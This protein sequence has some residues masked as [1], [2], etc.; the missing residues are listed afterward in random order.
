M[1]FLFRKM[2][3]RFKGKF[4]LSSCISYGTC[5]KHTTILSKLIKDLGDNSKKIAIIVVECV[6]RV[7]SK[8]TKRLIHSIRNS[9]MNAKCHHFYSLQKK[10]IWMEM[11]LFFIYL[12]YLFDIDAFRRRKINCAHFCTNE[13]ILSND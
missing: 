7:D 11:F 10:T 6:R 3:F 4:R 2:C 1:I 9:C 8:F 5:C 13:F 12:V